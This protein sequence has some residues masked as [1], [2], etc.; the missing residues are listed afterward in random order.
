M[1]GQSPWTAIGGACRPALA[2]VRWQDSLGYGNYTTQRPTP[3]QQMSQ[4]SGDGQGNHIYLKKRLLEQM[5]WKE[6]MKIRSTNI[7]SAPPRKKK[8]AT[9]THRSV[10]EVRCSKK[11]KI[12]QNKLFQALQDLRVLSFNSTQACHWASCIFGR[13]KGEVAVGEIAL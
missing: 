8:F 9:L 2:G 10:Y 6:G 12:V 13:Y 3:A 1:H 5:K 7:E 11:R 4:T